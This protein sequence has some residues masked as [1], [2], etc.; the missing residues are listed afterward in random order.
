M[1]AVVEVLSDL[2]VHAIEAEVVLE[3]GT[4][5]QVEAYECDMVI[6]GLRADQD[7]IMVEFK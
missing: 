2:C 6:V 5:I 3:D 1:G 7:I 4:T